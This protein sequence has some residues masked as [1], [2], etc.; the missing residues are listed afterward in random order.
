[1]QVEFTHLFEQLNAY[2]TGHPFRLSVALKNRTRADS[3]FPNTSD[4]NSIQS[5]ARTGDTVLYS[6]VDAEINE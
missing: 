1:M 2:K 5:S 4:S 6:A 3:N